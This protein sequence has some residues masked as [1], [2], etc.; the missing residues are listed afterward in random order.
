MPRIDYSV[1]L[2]VLRLFYGV[3]YGDVKC[4]LYLYY[5]R[6]GN[7]YGGRA[8]LQLHATCVRT[9]SIMIYPLLLVSVR[10]CHRY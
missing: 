5:T 10:G 7:G 1:V 6:T 2:R 3:F 8:R 9:R 4:H